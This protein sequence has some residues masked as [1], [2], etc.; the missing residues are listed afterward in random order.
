[1]KNSKVYPRL[2]SRVLSPNLRW[3]RSHLSW[4]RFASGLQRLQERDVEPTPFSALPCQPCT[5][6]GLPPPTVANGETPLVIGDFSPL[7]RQVGKEW[8]L[9]YFPLPRIASEPVAVSDHLA[10][11]CS[12][13]PLPIARGYKERPQRPRIDKF[14]F[15]T[16]NDLGLDKKGLYRE[17]KNR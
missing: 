7:S 2:I 6:W 4:S 16:K 11:R 12:D 3:G 13:F 1:M 10:L 9:W 15:N 5:G 8:S 14:I 17:G